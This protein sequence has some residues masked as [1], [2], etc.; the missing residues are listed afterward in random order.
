MQ[1]AFLKFYFPLWAW[2]SVLNY[3]E[4]LSQEL[5]IT[6]NLKLLEKDMNLM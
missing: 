5:V 6:K 1:Y 4:G 3:K 2:G